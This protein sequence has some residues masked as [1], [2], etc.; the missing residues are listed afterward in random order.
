MIAEDAL[1]KLVSKHHNY[2]T[3]LLLIMFSVLGQHGVQDF[4][5]MQCSFDSKC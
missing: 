3:L 1:L 2:V 5:P 4:E